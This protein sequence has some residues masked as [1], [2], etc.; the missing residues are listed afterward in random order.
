[1]GSPLTTRGTVEVEVRRLHDILD[2][3]DI[4]LVFDLLSL[5]IEGE[6]FKVL[7]DLIANSPIGPSGS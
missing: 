5:D 1:M 3:H 6:D 7:N 4:P 2:E